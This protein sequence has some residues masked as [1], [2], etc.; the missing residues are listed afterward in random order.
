M[1]EII[2]ALGPIFL[3]ILL[4]L[5]LRKKQIVSDQ[6]WAP[7]EQLTYYV[8]FPALLVQTTS[9]A[10]M[11]QIDVAPMAF[12]VMISLIFVAAITVKSRPWLGINDPTF[13]SVFQGSIRF[14]TYVGIAAASALWGEPGLTLISI[15]V[16]FCVPL[17]N[18]LCVVVMETYGEKEVQNEGLPK[19]KTLLRAV[20]KNP[21]ILACI[22]GLGLNS[23]DLSL[24]PILEPLLEILARASLPIGLLC[25]GAG[26][27]FSALKKAGKTV[28]IS[29]GVKLVFVPIVALVACLAFGVE[30]LTRDL[31]IF[32]AGLPV[33]TSSF[34]LARQMGGNAQIMSSI[35][36]VTTLG[37][38]IS[39]P[40]ILLLLDLF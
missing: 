15:C 33:A 4:G 28:A 6:F 25:V 30:G 16:A 23:L 39:L 2:F 20:L 37:A 13:T 21:L 38:M 22:F 10:D 3:L 5:A 8:F 34:I 14:N 17:V 31:C 18:V 26:L 29:S 35:I 19:A 24:P 32:F 36:T 27:S 11:G 9:K 7:A 12:V 1:I 40:V